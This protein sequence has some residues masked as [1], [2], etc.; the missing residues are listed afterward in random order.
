MHN[1][2]LKAIWELKAP[3]DCKKLETF[4]GLAVYFSAYIPYFSWMANP[5][6][7]NLQQKDSPFTWTDTHQTCLSSSSWHWSPLL[8][9]GTPSKDKLIDC[10]LMLL[11]M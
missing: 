10:T 9:E 4:L 2:K 6:F 1:K 3:K 5:L 8:C 11:N 7:K